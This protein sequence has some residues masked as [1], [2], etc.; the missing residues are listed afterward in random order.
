[1]SCVQS[2][3]FSNKSL[4][5]AQRVVGQE[6]RMETLQRALEK[7]AESANGFIS[8]WPPGGFYTATFLRGKF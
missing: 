7:T 5:A 2:E 1:M 3:F 6:A 8:F 4:S